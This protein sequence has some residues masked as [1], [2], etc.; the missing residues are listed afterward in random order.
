MPVN[1]PMRPDTDNVQPN[2]G[3]QAKAYS[4]RSPLRAPQDAR[5]R[6]R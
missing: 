1:Q 3:M 2:N 5:H 6:G 4:V